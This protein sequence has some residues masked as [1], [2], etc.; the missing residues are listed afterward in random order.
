MKYAPYVLCAAATVVALPADAA[1]VVDRV[2]AVV[3]DD[4]ILDSEVDQ[5]AAPLLRQP[6]DTSTEDGQ[7]KW[8]EVRRKALDNL[9]ESKLIQQQA[10][11][12]KLSVTSEEVDRAWEEVKRQNNLD[13]TTFAEALKQQGFTPEAY[14]KSLKRQML[15]M[16]VLN[17]AVR[18]RVS[19]SDDEVKQFYRQNE[20]QMAGE[21]TAHLRQIL[22][23]VP[24]D[25]PDAE[26]E[27]R[28]KI[29]ETVIAAAR[30]GTSFVE[31]AKKYSDDDLTKAEGGD[32]GWIG[33]G[34]LQDALDEA[35]QGMDPGDVR[36]PVR[37][38]RGWHVLQLVERKA[39]DMRPFDEVKDQIRR[40]LY[41]QQ[42]EKASQSWIRELRKKAH[43]DVRL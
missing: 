31:L 19:V 17:T 23:A 9:I 4:I 41:D 13:D 12:L 40:Q 28:K 34:V 21:K 11:E 27:R 22:I 42:V 8:A 39:G 32:L 14:R 20:R 6:L 16:K 43:L 29:A 3:N 24:T 18:A 38:A 33:K 7:K 36:G 30:K 25:A 35:V 37:T 2:V 15:E 1:K 5:F 26:V 10:Q